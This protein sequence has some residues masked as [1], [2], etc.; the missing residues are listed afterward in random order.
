MILAIFPVWG[1]V[2]VATCVLFVALPFVL[3]ML[4]P[5]MANRRAW[6]TALIIALFF[7]S[8]VGPVMVARSSIFHGRAK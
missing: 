3:R 2:A 1:V 8:V 5:Q 6:L 4:W 7:G